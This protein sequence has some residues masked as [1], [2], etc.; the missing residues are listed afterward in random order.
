MTYY[1]KLL[2]LLHF[3]DGLLVLSLSKDRRPQLF[4]FSGF[5]NEDLDFNDG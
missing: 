3:S 4:P 1:L 5:D 2:L